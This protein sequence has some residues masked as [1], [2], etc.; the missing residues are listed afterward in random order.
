M[1]HGNTFLFRHTKEVSISYMN[2]R[3]INRSFD[4]FYSKAALALFGRQTD[5][6]KVKHQS[7]VIQA[8]KINRL[9]TAAQIIFLE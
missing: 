6:S 9:T 1:F 5:K 8:G 2:L 4:N 3:H 7:N